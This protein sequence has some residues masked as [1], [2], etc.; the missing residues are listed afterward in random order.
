MPV[1]INNIKHFNTPKGF[2]LIEVLIAIF[3]LGIVMTTVYT[4][5]NT[6]VG[7]TEAIEGGSDMYEMGK[8]CL[9]RMSDDLLSIYISRKPAYFKPEFGDEP[10]PYRIV[11]EQSYVD[12][13][14]F[15]KLKFSSLAHI[16]FSSSVRPAG[17]AE[18][19]YY[20][21]KSEFGGY[22]LRR[23][24]ALFPH[25]PFEE[26]TSDPVICENI[27]SLKFKFYD[28]EG[29][30][31]ETWDSES[32]EFDYATPTSI[33]IRLEI[34]NSENTYLFSTH[35]KLALCRKKS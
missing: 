22:V 16:P 28:E 21:S 3:I 30:E 8:S 4:S 35:V 14:M 29:E 13:A 11:G 12:D 27:K 31:Y 34:G 15:T 7:K 18:I 17:I 26:N 10:E 23:F 6:I 9:N 2:T 25:E 32:D 24:D 20:V 5:F 1:Q 33:D 19:V